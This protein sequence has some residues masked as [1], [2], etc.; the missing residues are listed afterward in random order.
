[1]GLGKEARGAVLTGPTGALA[2]TLP[3]PPANWRIELDIEPAECA[4]RVTVEIGCNGA[5]LDSV[6][7]TEPAILRLHV[8]DVMLDRKHR[9]CAAV[10]ALTS[11]GP[12]SAPAAESRRRLSG[13]ARRVAAGATASPAA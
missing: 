9:G 11:A 1:M 5:P 7:V 2:F 10:S 12:G 13:A 6:V 4:G 8:P 3:E